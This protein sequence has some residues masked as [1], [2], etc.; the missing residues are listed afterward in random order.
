MAEAPRPGPEARTASGWPARLVL[1]TN[2]RGK[3]QEVAAILGAAGVT[4]V[5]SAAV[6]PGWSV[7]EDGAT[8]AANARRQPS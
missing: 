7:V 5:G 8:L 1:A 3:L 4:V 6:A 2:N